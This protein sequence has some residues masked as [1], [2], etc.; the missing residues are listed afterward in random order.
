MIPLA[1][2]RHL[3]CLPLNFATRSARCALSDHIQSRVHVVASTRRICYINASLCTL[4]CMQLPS[5]KPRRRRLPRVQ[6]EFRSARCVYKH[7]RKPSSGIYAQKIHSERSA[8][9][10]TP[11][12]V[13]STVHATSSTPPH[14]SRSSTHT[15]ALALCRDVSARCPHRMHI[16]VSSNTSSF[17]STNNPTLTSTSST[18]CTSITPRRRRQPPPP[19]NPQL[20]LPSLPSATP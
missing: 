1:L 15:H 4:L 10:P 12:G 18:S 7:P 8:E 16:P 3:P 5:V 20:P 13:Q 2:C 9:L 6:L 17:S 14:P 19:P 11:E